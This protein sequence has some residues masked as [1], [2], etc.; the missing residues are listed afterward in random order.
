MLAVFVFGFL[1]FLSCSPAYVIR[2]G[3]EEA[4]ILLR[5]QSIATLIEEDTVDAET[6]RK[7]QLVLQAREF[8]KELGLEPKGSFSK[9]TKIDRDVLVWVLTGA[10]MISLTPVTWWF[11]IV[12]SIPYKGFFE[13]DDALSAA[14][15]LKKKGFDIYLRPSPAFST[16]GWFNDP[17][18][19]T[20]LKSKD[21]DL[22][23]TVIHEILHGTIWVS[24][25]V[26]FNESLANFVGTVGAAEFFRK[27]LGPQDPLTIEAENLWG[28]EIIYARFLR[29]LT[30]RL[31]IVY[32]RGS[33]RLIEANAD[34]KDEVRKS[35]LKER[36]Q[37]FLSAK[38]EWSGIEPSLKTT[39]FSHAVDKLNNSVILAQKTYFDSLWIFDDFYKANGSSLLGSISSLKHLQDEGRLKEEP[40]RKVEEEAI[41]LRKSTENRTPPA[42]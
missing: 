35:I 30:A 1:T 29:T 20:T 21:L 2:A 12:G 18:L 38:E 9:Y 7:L 10:D 13:K 4:G 22:V 8:A 24:G 34:A 16:L 41:L 26:A 40:F 27:H 11:P 5:R 37:I 28:D 31:E 15:G 23:N 14:E 19:S 42:I 36:E 33:E 3:W 39:R 6:K 32:S 17:L 25:E